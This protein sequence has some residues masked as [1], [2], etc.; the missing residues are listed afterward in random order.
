M[1]DVPALRTVSGTAVF[2]CLR[3]LLHL[4]AGSSTSTGIGSGVGIMFV[5][6]AGKTVV[7]ALHCLRYNL[8]QM[9]ACIIFFLTFYW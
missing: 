5:T 1:N 6:V 2:T 4:P 9:N 8:P 3:P 7:F